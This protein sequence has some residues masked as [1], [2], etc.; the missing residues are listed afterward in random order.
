MSGG[1]GPGGSYG[2]GCTL[3]RVLGGRREKGLED[4]RDWRRSNG[5]GE[6][7][8]WQTP[9]RI[10]IVVFDVLS[11]SGRDKSAPRSCICPVAALMID[12]PRFPSILTK[13]MGMQN[14]A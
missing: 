10:L 8:H 5:Q 12:T 13:N 9:L 1:G 6:P 2:R 11:A 3:V 14:C 7:A 4:K